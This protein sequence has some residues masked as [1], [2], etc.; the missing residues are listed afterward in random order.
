MCSPLRHIWSVL[1]SALK[2]GE[3]SA[4]RHGRFTS[5]GNCPCY[6][7]AELGL[8]VEEKYLLFQ[9]RIERPFLGCPAVMQSLHRLQLQLEY[10]Q[11]DDNSKKTLPQCV[12]KILPHGAVK[13]SDSIAHSPDKSV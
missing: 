9:P 4:S 2:G 1:T 3:W 11:R 8:S 10:L 13:Y 6:T 12:R 5:P 7:M